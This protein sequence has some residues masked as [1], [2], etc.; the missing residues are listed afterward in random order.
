[1]HFSW[2]KLYFDIF[3][4]KIRIGDLKNKYRA[5]LGPNA[6]QLSILGEELMANVR[7]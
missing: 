1:M 5:L 7:I 4:L 2:T 3:A 6:Q